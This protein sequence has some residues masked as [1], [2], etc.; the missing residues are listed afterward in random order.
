MVAIGDIMIGY[1][2]RSKGIGLNDWVKDKIG[3]TPRTWPLFTFLF[4]GLPPAAKLFKYPVIGPLLKWAMMFSPYE[5]R[6][7]QG[8]TLPLNIEIPDATSVA[9][10]I[11]MI[12]AAI[13][14]AGYILALNHCLCRDSHNCQT[15]PHDLAC[16]FLGKAAHVT[17]KHG[18]GRVVTA[19][20]ACA[21]VDRA[22]SLGLV[23][24][25]LWVEVEQYVWG[26]ENESLENFLE[27][28]FCCPCCCTALNITRNS[29]LDV[30]RR[31]K[32]AGWSAQVS[33]SC[34]MCGKCAPV[35]PQH[36]ISYDTGKTHISGECF[37]CGLC[38]R[39][40]SVDAISL[41]L[42]EPP[43]AAIEDYFTGLKIDITR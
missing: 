19:E 39:E 4:R 25:A 27:I 7:T 29:T 23:G 10:P 32:S 11:D 13:H 22:A 31:F 9:V 17:E 40:C 38:A 33:D 8:V 18:L 6:F 2:P 28:C 43:K 41:T 20:E 15:Y 3:A 26:F 30:R 36:A 1:R 37:G 21:Q 35:C 24:Q 5:K 42:R 12:K 14:R 34:V 16:L